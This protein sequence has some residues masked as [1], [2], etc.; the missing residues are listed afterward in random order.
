MMLG[1]GLE[2][3]EGFSKVSKGRLKEKDKV[4]RKYFPCKENTTLLPTFQLRRGGR[5]VY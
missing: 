5:M 2:S 4:Q 3:H 1:H